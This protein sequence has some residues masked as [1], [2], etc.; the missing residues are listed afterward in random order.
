DF[1]EGL[2]NFKGSVIMVTNEIGLGGISA[3]PLAREFADFSGW[4]N[5]LIAKTCDEVY[6]VMAGINIK[7]K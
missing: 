7:L 4:A 1:Y 6:L 2:K 5:S 3:N